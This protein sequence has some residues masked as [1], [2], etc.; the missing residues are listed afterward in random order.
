MSLFTSW[1]LF[2][3]SWLCWTQCPLVFLPCMKSKNNHLFWLIGILFSL[4]LLLI[5]CYKYILPLAN[6]LHALL[7]ALSS[8]RARILHYISLDIDLNTLHIVGFSQTCW[9]VDQAVGKSLV[10]NSD[11]DIPKKMNTENK[12]KHRN[13]LPLFLNFSSKLAG[14]IHF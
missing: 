4:L 8:S 1:H 5:L 12:N 2:S 11:I 7:H 10:I 6:C 9:L 13:D 3:F 14:L